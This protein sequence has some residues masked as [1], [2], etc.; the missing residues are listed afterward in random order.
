MRQVKVVFTYEGKKQWVVV[1]EE[2]AM[3]SQLN[4]Y[5]RSHGLSTLLGI[6]MKINVVKQLLAM[7]GSFV[8][9]NQAFIETLLHEYILIYRKIKDQSNI[10]LLH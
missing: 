7:K 5:I 4:D 10:L 8:E 3:D 1:N 2:K 9:D 6:C